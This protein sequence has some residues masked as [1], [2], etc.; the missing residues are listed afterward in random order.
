MVRRVKAA[1]PRKPLCAEQVR[2]KVNY[3]LFTLLDIATQ[4]E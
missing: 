4:E 2:Y 1:F 3:S